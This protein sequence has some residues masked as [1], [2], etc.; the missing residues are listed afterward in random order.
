MSHRLQVRPVRTPRARLA[1]DRLP[2]RPED[3]PHDP[4]YGKGGGH[5]F[6]RTLRKYPNTNFY[7][8]HS[9]DPTDG[10]GDVVR[11]A[12]CERDPSV[13][14]AHSRGSPRPVP[15]TLEPCIPGSTSSV[16][17]QCGNL[18]GRPRESSV[19]PHPHSPSRVGCPRKRTVLL[20]TRPS[21]SCLHLPLLSPP[22]R[23]PLSSLLCRVPPPRV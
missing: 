16:V 1:W 7:L 9:G 3:H 4:R 19:R 10:S 11:P 12:R 23:S 17:L 14:P 21:V 20:Q 2:N 6:R 22:L 18:Q 13:P 15:C 5:L 8:L